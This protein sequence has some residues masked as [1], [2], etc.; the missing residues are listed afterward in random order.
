MVNE[1]EN[2]LTSAQKEQLSHRYEKVQ[3][4]TAP[5]DRS[6]L[7]GEGFLTEGTDYVTSSKVQKECQAFV[8]SYY[9]KGKAY[10]FFILKVFP[11]IPMSGHSKSSL[12]SYLITASLLITE[13]NFRRSLENASKIIK[14]FQ[15]TL[16]NLKS[17]LT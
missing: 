6:K 17:F 7:R 13:Q 5:H 4:K 3:R 12:R 1:A 15:I 2:Q 10:D 11:S 14:L 8:L 9:L 16:S